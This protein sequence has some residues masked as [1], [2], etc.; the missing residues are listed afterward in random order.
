MTTFAT[1][2]A[3]TI[4]KRENLKRTNS[5][6]HKIGISDFA[7]VSAIALAQE[8][9]K[10]ELQSTLFFVKSFKACFRCVIHLRHI[11][12]HEKMTNVLYL[13][14]HSK[15][16]TMYIKTICYSRFQFFRLCYSS[17]AYIFY[18]FYSDV[19]FEIISV[20]K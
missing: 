11:N 9:S 14:K 8:R 19:R 5:V 7:I 20:V 6:E 2:V 17:F 15:D 16:S 18:L 3:K 1:D 10:E 12:S 4:R 13:S